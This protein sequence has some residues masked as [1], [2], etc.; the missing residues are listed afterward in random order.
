[1][2][3]SFK[4]LILIVDTLYLII[5]IILYFIGKKIFNEGVNVE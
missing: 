4:T 3:S 5:I 1:M 2:N